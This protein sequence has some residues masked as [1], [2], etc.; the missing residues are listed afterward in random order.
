[1]S[2]SFTLPLRPHGQKSA[3]PDAL[4]IRIA[5]INAQRGSFRNVSEQSL[6]EEI[7]ARRAAGR[8][9]DETDEAEAQDAK[10]AD[11]LEQLYKSRGEIVDFAIQAHNEANYALDFISLLL[12]KHTPRQA[13]L[14]MSPYVKQ[15]APLGSLGVDIVKTPEQTETAKKEIDDVSRGWKLENFGAAANKL[16]Q[17]ASRLEEEV[18]AE[19]KYWADVLDIKEKGWKICRLPRERQTLGVQFGF[20]EATPTFRDRGLA[21][22]RRGEGGNPILDRGVRTSTPRSLRVRVQQDSQIVG[23]SKL[24]RLQTSPE[25]PIESRIRLARDSL[26]EEELFHEINR[27]ARA[28][29]HHGIE[30]KQNL[31]QFQ[32]SDNQHVLIDMVGLEEATPDDQGHSEDALAE[33]V[34][35][36]LR[37]L[38]SHAHRQKL[39]RRTEIPPPVTAKRRANPE[40][41]LLQPTLCYLQHKADLQWL[42]SFLETLTKTLQSAGL[43]PKYH[44][45]PLVS[46]NLPSTTPS[47]PEIPPLAERLVGNLLSPLESFVTGTFL[48][49]TS[50]FK[51]KVRTNISPNSFGTEF[52]ISTNISSGPQVQ[53]SSSRFGLRDDLQQLILYLFTID[54]VYLI[55]SLAG[56]LEES[57]P[58]SLNGLAGALN[59]DD[60]GFNSPPPPSP[61]RAMIWLPAFPENGELSAFSPRNHRAKKIFL[62]IQPTR[63]SVR[64]HWQGDPGIDADDEPLDNLTGVEGKNALEGVIAHSWCADT[65]DTIMKDGERTLKDVILLISKEDA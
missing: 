59:Q 17:S 45:S 30:T 61:N 62:N 13:E 43:K 16:L 38:L 8:D 63:L 46:V 50:S 6:Q 35:Q 42:Q 39:R 55:P 32:A 60:D 4:P 2:D 58:T 11:R 34:A 44:L 28:L 9:A 15:R 53:S 26:Y 64:S 49:P 24:I 23:A 20:M 5:Q 18:A 7:D 51:I 56:N 22:L 36:S 3:E 10:P 48:S 40:Y 57:P 31:I 29:L 54:L 52:Q 47:D 14:S 12:S 19:T 21:A 1:M 27:E 33:S 65:G 37:I 25:D 41:S